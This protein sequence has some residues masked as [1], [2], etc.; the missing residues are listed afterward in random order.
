M[1]EDKSA[2][3]IRENLLD[4]LKKR[5]QTREGSFVFELASP[6]AVEI[7]ACY[8]AIAAMLPAFYVDEGSGG[9]ID[10]A[11]AKFGISRKLG[12][13][14]GGIMNFFGKKGGIIPAGTRFF[15]ENGLEFL[16]DEEVVLD[17]NGKGSGNLT[18]EDVGEIGNI[19]AGMITKM[20]N[21]VSGLDSWEN[22]DFSGGTDLESDEALVKRYYDRLQKPATSGNIYDYEKWACE[23]S[24]VGDAKVVPLWNGPG[25]VKVFLVNQDRKPVEENV[26]EHVREH[27]EENRPVGADVTVVSASGMEILVN[28]KVKLDGSVGISEVKSEFSRKLEDYFQEI[29][30]KNDRV[31]FNKIAFLLMDVPGIVDFENL[32]VNG[33]NESI[34]LD[35]NQVP[36]LGSV[37][38]S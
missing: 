30:L 21:M 32:T 15:T 26:V 5:L 2:E 31:L 6:V 17:E 28:A 4:P 8:Q 12:T 20:A 36:V 11:A 23:V 34:F 37:I 33:G 25:T 14:A 22:E 7:A 19:S 27:I 38:L 18:A 29:A 13:K 1:F 3:K 16:L 9:F 10:L 24:G 35:E